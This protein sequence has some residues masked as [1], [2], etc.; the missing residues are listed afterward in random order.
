MNNLIKILI[1]LTLICYLGCGKDEQPKQEADAG[2]VKQETIEVA[3]LGKSVAAYWN[4]VEAGT[5][6]AEKD[7][8]LKATFYVPQQEDVQE[9]LSRLEDFIAKGVN[10]IA[11]A[12]SDP[13]A[14]KKVVSKALEK[15]IHC[16]TLDTD[17][18]DTGRYVY[19]GTG[20]YEA[21]KIAGEKMVE[22]LGGNG[23]VAIGV[24]SITA[25]NAL[26]RINGFKEAIKGTKIYIVEPI[27]NDKED[28]DTAIQNANGILQTHPDLVGFYG[29][30]AINGPAAA[31][32]I[33]KA[34]KAGIIKIVCFDTTPDIMGHVIAGT[35]QAT[36]AQK[37]FMMGYL[38]VAVLYNIARIG[39]DKT[40]MMLPKSKIIDTGVTVVTPDTVEKYRQELQDMG[41]QVEF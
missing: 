26:D 4:E 31:T 19:I 39:K 28:M 33:E 10:G 17:A 7:L 15:D 2:E 35:I 11:F 22:L 16:I 13:N 1:I 9:Q 14:V 20:N 25:Q 23:K 5:K 34:G 3:V 38:S 29:V 37:P 32:A 12:A 21:G 36:I 30:Y 8:G 18:P 41:I 24:G 27:L 6:A 40:L